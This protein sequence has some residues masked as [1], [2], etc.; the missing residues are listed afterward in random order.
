MQSIQDR[1]G[2]ISTLSYDAT[3]N[4]Q[5]IQDTSGRIYQLTYDG[6]RRI[7]QITDPAGRS[8]SYQYD[9]IGNLIKA[10]DPK[11]QQEVYEYNDPNDSHNITK[12]DIGG[13]YIFNYEYDESDRCIFSAGK[14][15][16]YRTIST[17]RAQP[18][19]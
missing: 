12:Q 10:I 9:A 17:T 13:E 3:G 18:L 4:L 19:P 6:N 16:C 5:T 1:H 14:T 11:G 8:V 7:T 15:D 2:N